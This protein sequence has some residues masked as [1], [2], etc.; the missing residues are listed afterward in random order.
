[1]SI[2]PLE[3]REAGPETR[4]IYR[5]VAAR[6]GQLPNLFKV[7]GHQP[8][9]AAPFA[10]L[11]GAV[12]AD[13]LLP[14]ALK[15]LLILVVAQGNGSEYCTLHHSHM[16]ETAGVSPA[17]LAALRAGREKES[18]AFDAGEIAMIAFA[19]ALHADAAAIPAEVWTELH[20][21]WSEAQIVD[22]AFVV[23]L[24]EGITRLVDALGVEAEQMFADRS[25]G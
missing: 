12:L 4:E 13:G 25:G 3:P 17:R 10:E 8:A 16:A 22:A 6:M 23:T 11:A 1:M 9:Y 24:F 20:G 14:A 2:A 19:R 7:L 15:E 18:G 21:H 5:T